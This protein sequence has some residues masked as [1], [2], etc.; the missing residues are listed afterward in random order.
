MKADTTYDPSGAPVALKYTKTSNCSSNCVWIDEQVLES[1]HG[2][3]R[4]HKWAGQS[5]QRYFYDKAGRLIGVADDVQPPGAAEGCTIRAYSF[6]AN[7]NRTSMNTIAPA[8]NGDCQP[9]ATGTLKTYSY[10]DADR[11][12]G[13]GIEYDKFG[14]MTSI[15]AQ[16]SGGGVLTYTYY[17][18]DQ[19]R[20]IAQDGVSKTYAL[21]PMGRQRQT[22]ATGGTTHT[23]TLHYQGGS[24][25]PSWS[26][27]ANVQ[28]VETSWERNIK[29]ID[30]DLAAIRTH[31]SQGDTTV[32]QLQNLHGDII[33]T[34]STDPNATA[35]TARFETDEFGNPRAQTQRRY[36]WLGGKQRRA[37]LASGV[38]QMGVRSY[39]P[40]LGRFT[41]VDPIKGG[42]ANDYDYSLA[43]PINQYDL[44][45]RFVGC[46]ISDPTLKQKIDR[47]TKNRSFMVGA[48]SH[49]CLKSPFGKGDLAMQTLTVCIERWSPT[50]A[51]YYQVGKCAFGSKLTSGRL[52][53]SKRVVCNEARHRVFR[54]KVSGTI[55]TKS[56]RLCIP[57]ICTLVLKCV[58]S[59][60]DRNEG[61]VMAEVGWGLRDRVRGNARRKSGSDE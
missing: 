2:Q 32:L 42:A 12:T 50:E 20:T 23:E 16:H 44:S 30:G 24:D 7:S 31:N 8:E 48:G 55:H 27:V 40:A 14:R 58:S 4:D 41:S 21:D 19:V 29:G 53:V 33:A 18:N 51:K 54:V 3:W 25:S 5:E 47:K 56:G 60:V 52:K 10:D 57:G 39:V 43:D 15:P 26:R 59:E 46:R 11:L 22:V 28:G 36:G 6:D 1:I 49:T 37:E 61:S 45:G 9:G 34:A 38:I 17:A 35:L 13:T